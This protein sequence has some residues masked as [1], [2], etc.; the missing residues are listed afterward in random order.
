MGKVIG[1]PAALF[2]LL[3]AS[4]APRAPSLARAQSAPPLP[5]SAQPVSPMQGHYTGPWHSNGDYTFHVFNTDLD[6]KIVIDGTLDLTVTPDGHV[7]G[8]ATGKVDAPITD[9]GQRDV[10]SGYGTISGNVSGVLNSSGSA[11]V[12]SHPVIDMH[13]G[14]FVG[15]GYTV[16]RFIT[17]PDYTLT[18]TAGNCVSAQGS[19]SETDFPVQWVVADGA[20]QMVQAPG[21]GVA[22]GSW[23]VAS[24]RAATFVSLS[25]QVGDFIAHANSLLLGNGVT[26]AAVRA[27][28]I[29]PLTALESTIR[30]DPDVARCLLERLGVW[31]ASAV[32][33]L[34]ARASSLAGSSSLSDLRAAADL[35]RSGTSLNLDCS[36]PDGGAGAHLQTTE[37]A[38]L[39]G[40]LRSRSWDLA[41]LLA[42]ELI[43]WRGDAARASVQEEIDTALH[44]RL[45]T[46][47]DSASILEVARVAYALGDDADVSAAYKRLTA[48]QGMQQHVRAGKKKKGKKKP[49]R[50]T[51]APVRKKP[52]ATPTATPVKPAT[53][54]L[55]QTLSTGLQQITAQASGTSAPTLSWHPVTGATHYLVTVLAPHDPEILWTWSGTATSVTFGDTAIDGSA[56]T[57]GDGWPV[58]A[59]T[60]YRWTVTA[61]NGQGQIVGL[62]LR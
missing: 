5:C 13:W 46:I 21:I 47:S 58:S 20:G 10:S 53:P 57:G 43:L 29:Q 32:A 18:S 8:T 35:L 6:L 55:E 62:K 9:Y 40:A 39:D 15:G 26:P 27:Q 59:G 1:V 51:P 61:L 3:A 45:Q 4:I 28:I 50:P 33:G 60:G 37:I 2:V 17:M 41:V 22:D 12:L 49:G 44:L 31:E 14:T 16:E 56:S 25:N 24:D 30:Q 34:Y 38:A 42:R 36:I 11:L 19:I 7:T 52:V 54:T 23:H 48:H